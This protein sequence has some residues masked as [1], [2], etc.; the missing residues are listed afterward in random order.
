MFPFPYDEMLES[1]LKEERCP[2]RCK[3]DLYFLIAKEN[4]KSIAN[5]ANTFKV[6]LPKNMVLNWWTMK[7]DGK[8]ERVENAK[9]NQ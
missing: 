4:V 1:R 9:I 6:M 5:I 8:T 7:T 3:E 2:K